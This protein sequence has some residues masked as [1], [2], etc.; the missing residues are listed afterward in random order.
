MS[1][2]HLLA[3]AGLVAVAAC[4]NPTGQSLCWFGT[5]PELQGA[6]VQADYRCI[7]EDPNTERLPVPAPEAEPGADELE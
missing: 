5:G 6:D 3:L 2:K 1:L 4:Q 7:V